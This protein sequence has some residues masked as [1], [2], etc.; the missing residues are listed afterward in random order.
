MDDMAMTFHVISD[1]NGQVQHQDMIARRLL[2]L[3]NVNF[4]AG[5]RF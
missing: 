1:L 4:P 3:D 2:Q 5:I